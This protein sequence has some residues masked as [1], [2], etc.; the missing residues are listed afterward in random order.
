MT[1]TTT[2]ARIACRSLGHDTDAT[3]RGAAYIL[4]IDP[5]HSVAWRPTPSG[6]V[7]FDLAVATPE[8]PAIVATTLTAPRGVAAGLAAITSLIHAN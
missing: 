5:L 2:L 7:R 6:H 1:K 8:G 4:E 3:P